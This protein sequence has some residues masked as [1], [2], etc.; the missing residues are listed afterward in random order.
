MASRAGEG[1]SEVNMPLGCVQYYV[2]G[3]LPVKQQDYKKK[4]RNLAS[5]Y[6]TFS[7]DGN[8]LLVNLG[9]EQIY[10][11]DINSKRKTIKFGIHAEQTNKGESSSAR[12]SRLAYRSMMYSLLILVSQGESSSAC[13]SSLTYRSTLDSL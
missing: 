10:L 6:V 1:E 9:G 2:A 11:F 3:H 7:A 4:Y 12:L 8:E 13:L 5:T